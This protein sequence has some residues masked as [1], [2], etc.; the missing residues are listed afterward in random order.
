MSKD[1]IDGLEHTTD[2]QTPTTTHS[3]VIEGPTNEPYEEKPTAPE[4]TTVK[5]TTTKIPAIEVKPN[6]NNQTATRQSNRS[7]N[8]YDNNNNYVTEARPTTPSRSYT[9]APKD[10]NSNGNGYENN[11]DNNNYNNNDNNNN[12]NGGMYEY[13]EPWVDSGDV[14]YSNDP[15]GVGYRVTDDKAAEAI[16]DAIIAQ[17][18]NNPSRTDSKVLTKVDKPIHL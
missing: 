14:V 7:H 16:A 2:D 5:E 8:D 13:D 3:Y 18:S 15:E 17:M 9:E 1:P 10:N 11:N 6:T 4:T 12:N